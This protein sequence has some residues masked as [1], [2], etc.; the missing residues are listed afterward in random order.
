MRVCWVFF[1]ALVLRGTSSL[2]SGYMKDILLPEGSTG[3]SKRTEVSEELVS[4]EE[5]FQEC[6]PRPDTII[7]TLHTI[8]YPC[9]VSMHIKV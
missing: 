9:P 8:L 5:C 7:P 4:R 2:R 1:V 3:I 6:F